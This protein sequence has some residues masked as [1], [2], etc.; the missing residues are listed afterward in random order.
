MHIVYVYFHIPSNRVR[1]HAVHQSLVYG[2][3]VLQ[4]KWHNF[5]SSISLRWWRT[6]SSL[7]PLRPWGS[8]CI[9][10]VC[11]WN[12]RACVQQLGLLV[13]Q[14]LARGNYLLGKFCSGL[15]NQ[16]TSS[17]CYYSF[18]PLPRLLANLGRRLPWW[19]QLLVASLLLQLLLCCALVQIFSTSAI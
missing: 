5:F 11:P 19:N 3:C 12:L 1:E 4:S 15:W 10:K 18:L 17:I 14:S 2:S 9:Q 16:R 8:S 7:D 13:D 6:R